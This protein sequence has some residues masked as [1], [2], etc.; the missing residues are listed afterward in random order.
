MPLFSDTISPTP[1]GFF[2]SDTAF[3][4]E[5]DG[6]ITF[7]KRKLGDDVLSVELTRKEIWAC[8]EEACCEYSRLIHETKITSELTNVLGVNT[9]SADFTNKYS[10]QTL[11]YL[12]R[13]AEPYAT[14]AYVGGS[15]DATMCYVDLIS[16]QQDYDIYSD[17]KV[18]SGSNAGEVFFDTLSGSKGKLK[19]VE[20]FHFEPLAAQTFLL[21]ASNITNFLATNF[22]YESY[23][24]ST[25]FY[26]LPIF[27]DVLRRGM[28]ESAFRVRRSNYSYELLGS[29]LRIYPIPTSDLQLGKM[30]IKL[31]PPHDPYKP[32]Y[33]DNSIYGISGPNN[34]PLGNLPFA[35]I[36][37]PGRQWIRQYTLA[38]CK[39]L[40]GLIRSKFQNIPIPNADLQLNGEALISQG[41]ED[42][43]KL[44]NQM[45]EFLL[46]MTKSKLLE[47]D[48]LAAENLNK[49]LRF[50][51]MPLGKSIQIG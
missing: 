36:N 41:R 21:N 30:Y 12:L 49:Q 51:P 28:L 22:N 6:M 46:N 15:Y 3:Q 5:A 34:F 23:V 27:E 2:D 37:Q 8:F 47:N 10:R 31:M 18:L 14:E 9:G 38:L 13:M 35:T 26:V 20:I 19:I 48:A 16:G 33:T 40:L 1:F 11:E 7:V 45:K 17:V 44:I 43:D 42:K 25:I 4:A 50:I 24:N 39:E 29:K 32:L